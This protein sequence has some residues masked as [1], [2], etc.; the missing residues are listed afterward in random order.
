MRIKKVKVT[1]ILR[2]KSSKYGRYTAG[3]ETRLPAIPVDFGSVWPQVR[4]LSPCGSKPQ[5]PR[6]KGR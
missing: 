2:G 4:G 3:M 5:T 1:N 6:Q